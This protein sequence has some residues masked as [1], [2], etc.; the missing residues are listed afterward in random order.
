MEKR[1]YFYKIEGTR[2]VDL[3]PKT[4]FTELYSPTPLL[5]YLPQTRKV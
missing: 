1:K 3:Q 4:D 5:P 2:R